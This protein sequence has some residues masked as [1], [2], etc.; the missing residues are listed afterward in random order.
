MFIDQAAAGYFHNHV[1]AYIDSMCL[2][3]ADSFV[4]LWYNVSK[5]LAEKAAWEFAERESLQ[6]VVLNPGTTLGPFFT[7]SVNTSL[8]I[9]LQLLRGWLAI[10]IHHSV[11]SESQMGF[12]AMNKHIYG[13]SRS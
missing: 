6:L 2:R 8:N 9:L 1:H 3:L 10:V 12:H 4:Q 7:P 11:T 13:A 5:T